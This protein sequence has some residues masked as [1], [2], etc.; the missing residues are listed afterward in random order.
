M[1]RLSVSDVEMKYPSQGEKIPYF[2]LKNDRE[3]KQIRFLYNTIND[4]Y[5]D[6]VHDININNR[7][8]SVQCLNSDGAN[9]NACPLCAHGH[10]QIVKL[11]I[12]VLDLS[13]NKVKYWT[14]SRSFIA[15]LQG[16]AARNNPISGVV[17]EVMRIGA[18]RDPKT[19][20]VLQP[21]S[22]ND[23][24]TVESLNV[25]IPDYTGLMRVMDYNQMNNFAGT[26]DG[27]INSAM[28]VNNSFGNQNYQNSAPQMSQPMPYTNFSQPNVTN[29]YV[30]TQYNPQPS[31]YSAPAN[32]SSQY[33]G[34]E[35][36]RR[37]SSM[38]ST[39][40]NAPLGAPTMPMQGVPTV[41]MQGIP[42]N[43]SNTPNA[44]NNQL[45]T[46]NLGIDEDLPF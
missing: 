42:N 27:N 10:N 33:I 43:L 11:Y 9:P 35:P 8:Q 3:T 29:N 13:D 19:Q 22:M 4:I 31:S 37:Q 26:I 39:I 1:G 44:S 32:A 18:P 34:S 30:N 7:T 24:M 25:N 23:G 45:E 12:P 5:L 20:Y 38:P 46:Q 40:N 15:Q 21:V 14:R 36:V 17:V 2:S 16:L 6:V 41:P 28:P